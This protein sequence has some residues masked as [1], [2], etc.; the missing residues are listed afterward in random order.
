[1]RRVN[2]STGLKQRVNDILGQS[3]VFDGSITPWSIQAAMLSNVQRVAQAIVGEAQYG[4]VVKGLSLTYVSTTASVSAGSGIT[5]DGYV[6]NLSIPLSIDLSQYS[7]GKVY[8]YLKYSLIAATQTTPIAHD[9]G[10][11]TSFNSTNVPEEIV[12][13]ELGLVNGVQV[14]STDIIEVSTHQPSPR[15]V[16]NGHVYLGNIDI[17]TSVVT[18]TTDVGIPS[19]IDSS[20]GYYQDISGDVSVSLVGETGNVSINHAFFSKSNKTISL[21]ISF[22]VT[23]ISNSESSL[24]KLIVSLPDICK[25]ANR[26]AT[27]SSGNYFFT[28]IND[29]DENNTLAMDVCGYFYAAGA[30]QYKT[31][32]IVRKAS[33]NSTLVHF[34]VGLTG[35]NDARFTI[36]ISYEQA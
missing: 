28:V 16:L 30:N 15:A 26:Y 31:F 33:D 9:Y 20:T 18:S 32:N 27:S 5:P 3:D 34:L 8:F 6:I 24:S 14:S 29:T 22:T 25:C 12:F 21:D 36:N 7:S 4:R 35:T 23:S 1:M 17:D 2:V 11:N 10:K 13:D 19:L